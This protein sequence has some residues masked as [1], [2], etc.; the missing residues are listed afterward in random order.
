MATSTAVKPISRQRRSLRETKAIEIAPAT[1]KVFDFHGQFTIDR[2]IAENHSCATPLQ[3]LPFLR[4][5]PTIGR[6]IARLA[7]LKGHVRW[8]IPKRLT[9]IPS[10]RFAKPPSNDPPL[11]VSFA[12]IRSRP[13]VFPYFGT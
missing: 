10:L 12:Y 9:L 5:R 7:R 6:R 2:R 3:S 11:P 13:R 1:A 4:R 8:S